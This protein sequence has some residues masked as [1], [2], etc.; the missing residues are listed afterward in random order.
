MERNRDRIC[1]YGERWRSGKIIS[2]AFVESLVNQ[3][4]SRRFVKKQP[5]QWTPKGAHLLL[6]M[7][8]KTINGELAAAFR[9]WYPAIDLHDLQDH[10]LVA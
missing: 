6:Q 9:K 3:L 2:T 7:R 5:L 1:N 4:I 8:V 10:R